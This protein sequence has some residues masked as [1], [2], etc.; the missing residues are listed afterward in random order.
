[1]NRATSADF[2]APPTP[3]MEIAGCRIRLDPP[4]RFISEPLKRGLRR[5][6]ADVAAETVEFSL[7]AAEGRSP[8]SASNGASSRK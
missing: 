6:D 5:H 2:P 3:E 4:G 1:M 7:A 8:A